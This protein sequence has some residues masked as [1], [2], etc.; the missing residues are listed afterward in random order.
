MDKGVSLVKTWQRR[1]RFVTKKK[2][3]PDFSNT[4]VNTICARIG[5]PERDEG[6]EKENHSHE[7]VRMSAGV[8]VV[9]LLE[10]LATTFFLVHTPHVLRA[11]AREL[12]L[13][14]RLLRLCTHR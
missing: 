3:R 14:Q 9:Q 7:V 4:A 12:L 2:P 1:S 6:G 10:I 8:N 11:S 13:A 5:S